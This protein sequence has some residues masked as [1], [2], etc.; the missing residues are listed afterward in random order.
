LV[1]HGS[2][3]RLAVHLSECEGCGGEEIPVA[4]GALYWWNGVLLDPLLALAAMA[5]SS[6]S[7]VTKALRLRSYRR[8]A[9]VAEILRPPLRTRVT[10]WAYLGG[11]AVAAVSLGV[12]FSL[13]S[14]SDTASHGINGR[15]AWLQGTGM[16]V[17]P[18][19]SVMMT[20]DVPPVNAAQS[21]VTVDYRMS[22]TPR[23]GERSRIVVTL[24]DAHTGRR[25]PT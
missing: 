1:V 19:M 20:T 15:L 12:A 23:P 3:F 17:R 11:I 16:T 21:G 2:W 4:A 25:S 22:A 6:V 13:A 18:S 9:T 5:M 8:P 14:R 10:Q 7:V 24:R